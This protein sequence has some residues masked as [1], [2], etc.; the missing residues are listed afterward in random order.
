MRLWSLS[1]E[2]SVL[3]LDRPVR[4]YLKHALSALALTRKFSR[5]QLTLLQIHLHSHDF[6]LLA[7]SNETY[8]ALNPLV[9][10]SNNP[11]RRDVALL[12]AGGYLV[13]AFK[14]GN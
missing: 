4:Q 10:N 9:L 8:N 6:A 14:A 3:I 5:V 2:T 1:Q 13:T 11:P 12:P 7:Q